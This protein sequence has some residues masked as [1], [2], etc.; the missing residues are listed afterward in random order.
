MRIDRTHRRWFVGTIAALAVSGMVYVPYALS[1]RG[2][3]GGS[4]IGLVYGSAGFA[5]MLFAGLLGLR[6]RFPIWRIGRAQGWMRGHLWLGFLAFPMIL[7]HGGFHFGGTLTR[8]M[9]WMFTFVFVSGIAGAAIQHYM[10]RTHTAELPMETIY[11]Q[12]DH[13]RDQLVME[14]GKIVEE[15][16]AALA[17]E[18]THASERQLAVAASAGTNWDMTVAEGLNAD[19]HAGE[20]LRR[21]FLD[22]AL[23][24]L[25]KTGGRRYALGDP[26]RARGLFQQLRLN[27]PPTLHDAIG[28]LETLCEEKRQLDRQKRMHLMLHGWLLVHVPLSYAVLLL[29]AIHAVV[30]LKY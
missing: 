7:L 4:V 1:A 19:E 14:A 25:D 12:I 30:A 24:F 28:S 21:F 6:K 2:P 26:M 16:C 15:A 11:E 13:V 23:P 17:G 18:M 27:L 8:V 9:M 10:P 29:G 5:F 20:Q 3:R 22:E